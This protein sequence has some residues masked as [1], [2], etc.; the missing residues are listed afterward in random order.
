M[1]SPKILMQRIPNQIAA[2]L[3]DDPEASPFYKVFAE[4][5]DS[6]SDQD[7]QRLR[8]MARETIA[9]TVLPAYRELDQYFSDTYLP[10]SRESIGL[11]ELPDGSEW[12]E[13]RA[14]Q[15]T[16]TQMS[17]DDDSSPRPE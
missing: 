16:T 10:A 17:P 2:Q 11:S 3:V 7:Q 6:I 5:P 12:Y 1:M 8:A 9:E 4:M 13:H 15:F 14:R